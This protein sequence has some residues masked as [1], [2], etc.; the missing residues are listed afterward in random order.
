[1]LKI[2]ISST[3]K[4]LKT[5][6]REAMTAVRLLEYHEVAMEDY[7]ASDKRPLDKC[8]EDIRKCHAYVG[9]VGWRYG[10]IPSGQDK[11]ITHLE[12]DEAIKAGHK[13]MIFILDTKKPTP[14]NDEQGRDLEKVSQFRQKLMERHTCTKFSDPAQLGKYVMASIVKELHSGPLARPVPEIWP[15][16]TDRTVQ[17]HELTKAIEKSFTNKSKR[18]FICVVHGNE[19]ESHHMFSKRLC[20]RVLPKLLDLEKNGGIMYKPLTW[21]TRHGTVAERFERL[22]DELKEQLTGRFN[23]TTND[24]HAAVTN[25]ARPVL[26]AYHLSSYGWK[27]EGPELFEKYLNFWASW[28]NGLPMRLFVVFEME[29]TLAQKYSFFKRRELANVK[30]DMLGFFQQLQFDNNRELPLVVCS[31]LFPVSKSDAKLWARKHGNQ[32]LPMDDLDQIINRL[33]KDPGDKIPM[34]KLAHHLNGAFVESQV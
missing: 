14:K 22:I 30:K 2:Y 1:M 32:I 27:H 6:R 33:F 3:Y 4:D 10:F 9:I 23:A 16:L 25:Q 15:H 29:Y 17:I 21:P 31:E 11:S 20:K 26:V 19:Q 8:L 5:E 13:S 24:M 7:T 28:P 12:Y 18:P 34:E